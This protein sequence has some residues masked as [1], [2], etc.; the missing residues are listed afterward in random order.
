MIAAA[1][2]KLRQSPDCVPIDTWKVSACAARNG[3][4]PQHIID[5]LQQKPTCLSH[6][7]S[8]RHGEAALE[9]GSVAKCV[10]AA[11]SLQCRALEAGSL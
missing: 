10:A 11:A 2:A 1:S 8:V 3:S 7:S 9:G 6:T 5:L 4:T